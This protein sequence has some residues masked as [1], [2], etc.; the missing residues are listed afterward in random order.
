MV[1]A[2]PAKPMTILMNYIYLKIIGKSLYTKPIKQKNINTLKISIT[3]KRVALVVVGIL[4]ITGCGAPSDTPEYEQEPQPESLLE[5]IGEAS[6]IAWVGPHRDD[7]IVVTGFL[8][9]CTYVYKKRTYV[10]PFTTGATSFPPGATIEDRYKDNMDFK[11]FLQ[12][13]GYEPLGLNEYTHKKQRL[14]ELLDEFIGKTGVNLI[15][16]FEN[17]HGGNGH[18]D[19]ITGSQWLTEYCKTRGITLYYFINRDP[20]F[21]GEVDPLPYTDEIDLDSILVDT[22]T[23]MRSLWEI[24]VKVLE[25]Y[26]SSVPIA[27]DI[28]QTP[29]KLETMIHSEYY[30]NVY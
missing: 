6:A 21:G 26:S 7:E 9:L 28:I 23:G 16:T 20:L 24:K 15:V 17:T 1:I 8:A 12:L 18:P 2:G 11:I 19:H 30:R 14:F 27:A 4:L 25:I 5:A 29:G 10:V 22:G 13:A 3:M